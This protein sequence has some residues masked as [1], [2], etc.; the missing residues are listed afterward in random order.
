MPAAKASRQPL[1]T[2]VDASGKQ[3]AVPVFDCSA[4]C[5]A[6]PLVV[7]DGATIYLS[8]YGT[9][10]RGAGSQVTCTVD[11]VDVPALYA[12]PQLSY[13]GLDQVNLQLPMS[14]AGRGD[15]QLVLSANG[16]A[17]NTVTLN[18]R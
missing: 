17:A 2:R 3:S 16:V 15:V 6:V 8:L 5:K 7:D 9:G 11:G 13:A 10:I 4:G 12:G 18:I 1:A 14:L